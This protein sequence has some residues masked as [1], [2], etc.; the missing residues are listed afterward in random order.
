MIREINTL[1][2]IFMMMIFFHHI[3]PNYNGGAPAVAGFF[4]IGG[5]C[6]TLGYREKICNN[7]FSFLSFVKKR[8]IKFYL[9]HWFS[10]LLFLLFVQRYFWIYD[11]KLYLNIFLL[12]AWFPRQDVY[13]SYNSPSWYLGCALFFSIIFPTIICFIEK[14]AKHYRIL[15][16]FCLIGLNVFTYFLISPSKW[17]GFLYVNPLARLFDSFVGV[18]VAYEYVRLMET[19]FCQKL[20]SKVLDFFILISFSVVILLS[21][22]LTDNILRSISFIYWFPVCLLVLSVS[23][24]SNKNSMTVISKFLNLNLFQTASKIS[25]SFYLLH[26]VVINAYNWLPSSLLYYYN[27]TWIKIIVAFITTLIISILSYNIIEQG[28]FPKLLNFFNKK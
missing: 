16:F 7:E 20:S 23:L 28:L 9:I 24:R 21:F 27:I 22:F 4:I 1:R 26:S 18:F 14:I 3:N 25:L 10:L 8:I 15:I 19:N 12:Q 2:L 17:Q 13:Y 6:L 11:K 5:F